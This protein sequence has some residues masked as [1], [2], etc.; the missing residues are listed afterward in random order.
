M[1]RNSKS[2]ASMMMEIEKQFD[3]NSLIYNQYHVWPYI[4]ILLSSLLKND[5]ARK[6]LPTYIYS[7]VYKLLYGINTARQQMQSAILGKS[8]HIKAQI[9]QSDESLK[10]YSGVDFM[11]LSVPADYVSQLGGRYHNS[12]IDPYIDLIKDRHSFLKLETSSD[13]LVYTTPRYHEPVSVNLKN[14]LSRIPEPEAPD[15]PGL[16]SLCE[17]I[18]QLT[19]S[20]YLH[21]AHL[22]RKIADLEK[23]SRVFTHI[24]SI[25][26]PKV[27]VLKNYYNLHNMA[28]IKAARDMGITTVDIQ[29]GF[30]QYHVGYTHWTAVPFEGYKL[31]PDFFW[32]WGA[33]SKSYIDKWHRSIQPDRHIPLLGGHRWLGQCAENEALTQEAFPETLMNRIRKAGKVVLFTMQILR[34]ESALPAHVL[35]IMKETGR[36][37]WL[38]LIRLHPLHRKQSDVENLLQLLKRY[39]IENYEI[40][41]CSNVP[42]YPLLKIADHHIT[43]SSNCVYEAQALG[44][45]N[46][47]IH[48]DGL[49]YFEDFIQEGAIGVGLTKEQLLDRLQT[50][51]KGKSKTTQYAEISRE[52]SDNAVKVILS[53]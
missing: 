29:H 11:F 17:L 5:I 13:S 9:R 46:T 47:I 41:E 19:G 24:L 38:W 43:R 20:T 48:A 34:W 40:Q 1:L 32:T 31:L 53:K 21:P 25:V 49:S 50:T 52:V 18:A 28:L 10:S 23:T 37:D 2:V 45:P 35:E 26:K 12:Y 42:L 44:L 8:G 14:Y 27:I 39:E 33:L 3:V 36:N 51:H 22:Q 15:I 7:A 6:R 30:G 16:T 4:R